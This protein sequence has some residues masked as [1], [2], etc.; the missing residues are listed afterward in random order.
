[1]NIKEI[2]EDAFEIDDDVVELH[3]LETDSISVGGKKKGKKA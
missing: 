3:S 2:V 1:M